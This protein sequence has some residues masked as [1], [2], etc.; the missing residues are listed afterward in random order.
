ME[1]ADG[2]GGDDAPRSRSERL[3]SLQYL[4]ENHRTLHQQRQRM[5]QRVLLTTLTMYVLAAF[6]VLK[7]EVHGEIPLGIRAGVPVVFLVVALLAI[8]Y[9]YRIHRAN[10]INIRLA[11]AAEWEIVLLVESVKMPEALQN[12]ESERSGWGILHPLWWQ[13]GVILTFA[14]G[15][16]IIIWLGTQ[17]GA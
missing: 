15:S 5:E 1:T 10:H 11:E 7:G 17:S 9:L 13:G 2:T 3:S 16:A 8:A 4:S 6:A 12:L 14:I